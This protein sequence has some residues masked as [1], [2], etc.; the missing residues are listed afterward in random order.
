[1]L[2]TLP[3]TPFHQLYYPPLYPLA[4][5]YPPG[6]TPQPGLPAV[7]LTINTCCSFSDM[8]VN[9][10][11][12]II[13]LSVY[14]FIAVY[15]IMFLS[16]NL[17]SFFLF[18]CLSVI[19]LYASVYIYRSV[20]LS[21]YLFIYLSIYLYI[22]LSVYL[23]ICLSVYLSICLSVYLSIF[24]LSICLSVYLSICLNIYLSIL[25]CPPLCSILLCTIYR[26]N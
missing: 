15:V 5:K 23:S 8:L 16:V 21:I 19:Q 12:Q 11:R 13:Y 22:C 3:P 6:P 18:I 1:M 4:S 25:K 9:T 20:Y 24:Y 10:N 14:L 26:C 17:S 2:P 7:L